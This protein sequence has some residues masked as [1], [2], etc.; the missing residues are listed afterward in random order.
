ME[1][2]RENG[3]H[4]RVFITAVSC[5]AALAAAL[6]SCIESSQTEDVSVDK[7]RHALNEDAD[8]AAAPKT[9]AS[10]L[11]AALETVKDRYI[12]V[13]KPGTLSGAK[14]KSTSVMRS[15]LKS[16]F[17]ADTHFTYSHAI[18]GAA[19]TIKDKDALKRLENDPRVAYVVP[20]GVVTLGETQS[21]PTWGLDR[22]DQASPALDH[23]YTYE[24]TGRDVHVYVIDSGVYSGHNEFTGRILDGIDFVDDDMDPEDCHGH[25]THVA[26]TIL[27][28]VFGVAKE[29]YLHP[30]R[31]FACDNL[32]AQ[33]STVIA[34]VDW[35]TANF[36]YPAVADMSI[37]GPRNQALD[38]AVKA[39]I[40]A[41]VFFGVCAGN[42]GFGTI[43]ACTQSP[44]A[45][46][47]AMAVTASDNT[48][49]MSSQTGYGSCVDIIAPGVD[50]ESA[51]LGLPDAVDTKTGCSQA[52]PHVVGAAALLLGGRPDMTP[53][54][55]T[56][57]ILSAATVGA[58]ATPDT[59]TPNLLLNT[60]VLDIPRSG[61]LIFDRNKT[62]CSGSLSLTL[63]DD[64]IAGSGTVSIAAATSLGDAETITLIE[65]GA[66][67][68]TFEGALTLAEGS[69]H[70]RD[71]IVQTLDG[72]VIS[73]T[74]L[75][76]DDGSGNSATVTIHATADCTPPTLSNIRAIHIYDTFADI[77]LNSSEIANVH[78]TLGTSCGSLTSTTQ[79][80]PAILPKATLL[81]VS[82]LTQNTRYYFTVTA[83]DSAGNVAVSDNGGT[84]FSFTSAEQIF[85]EDFES[86]LGDFTVT[87]GSQWHL[88]TVCK[89]T[90]P[91]HTT[92]T[93]LYYGQDSTCTYEIGDA[94]QGSASSPP[95]SVDFNQKPS[96]SFN[97]FL[98][99]E[100]FG[101]V[102][103]LA[104]VYLIVAGGAPVKI[105]SSWQSDVFRLSSDTTQ[106][107]SAT[108]PLDSYGTGPATIQI[109]FEF[110]NTGWNDTFAGFFVDDVSVDQLP[111]PECT[112]NADCDDG[113][114]CTIDAC[115]V[116]FGVCEHLPN[117]D[118][119]EAEEM[120]HATGGAVADGWNIWDNGYIAFTHPFFG[121][122][123]QMTVRAA[124]QFGNGWPSMRVTVGGTQVFTGAV[125]SASWTD[126]TFSF[127]SPTGSREV[128]IYF[129]ND[130]YQP[131]T[132]RN[133]LIDKV[134]VLCNGTGPGPQPGPLTA[135]L[136]VFTDWG[137]GYCANLRITNNGS[138]PTTD[139]TVVVDTQSSSVNQYWN[140]P[141]VSGTG[142][143]NFKPVGTWNAVIQPSTTYAQTGFCAQR[144]AGSSALP[145]VVSAQGVY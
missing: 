66:L 49:T 112:A 34:A 93:A 102:S 106:W 116:V 61:K 55:I 23:A 73:A 131:P 5:A 77:E 98:N 120:V 118:V 24:G 20:D 59:G 51:G 39:S 90:L 35:V 144:P 135:D 11:E 138:A 37:Y 127:S 88:S 109:R 75:D 122:S 137:G 82:A 101:M 1:P 48:D 58:V 42:T 130:Y 83:V 15:S 139:W 2:L 128:R 32:F 140:T 115:N 108:I 97:Y 22:I 3:I 78:A 30:V 89:A 43:D 126:Y 107:M 117:D 7:F 121:G 10:M 74:Y 12:V 95:I 113:N 125:S 38:D 134:T 104:D 111:L 25:G 62:T 9:P 57:E 19:V 76:A 123:Q 124:G 27:G 67:P 8:P 105:A 69:P 56:T 65:D 53:A 13:F 85:F 100:P 16:E 46:P 143:H 21:N 4:G 80:R 92:P 18:E 64:G 96:V 45:V 141:S 6:P 17:G 26:G 31:V 29:A 119:Y 52:T 60:S 145:V 132:D 99:M 63:R 72:A 129:T 84:C 91:R 79:T 54:E 94:A 40:A 50:I 110:R 87:D 33:D 142:V 47:E 14:A 103:D 81:P 44:A 133:L 136:N 28:T 36:E 41:G 68:G 70:S 71:G 114:V 86:G